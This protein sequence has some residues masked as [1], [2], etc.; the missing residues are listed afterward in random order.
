MEGRGDVLWTFQLCLF[1]AF[2]PRYTC[3]GSLLW[4]S[5]WLHALYVRCCWF[6]ALLLAMAILSDVGDQLIVCSCGNLIY[7]KSDGTQAD[8]LDLM[9]VQVR[10]DGRC[11]ANL[12]CCTG[13]RI[14]R[15]V[16]AVSARDQ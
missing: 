6:H 7:L 15:G 5:Y 14:V 12:I 10:S 11:W 3:I 4:V 1:V 9:M 16:D 8:S 2:I 13:G